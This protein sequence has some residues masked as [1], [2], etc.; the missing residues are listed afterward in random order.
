MY[1]NP[2]E[3]LVQL[4]DKNLISAIEQYIIV[5]GSYK[6]FMLDLKSQLEKSNLDYFNEEISLL[7]LIEIQEKLKLKFKERLSC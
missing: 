6:V 5:D 7:E 4:S 3:D 1:Y 2:K